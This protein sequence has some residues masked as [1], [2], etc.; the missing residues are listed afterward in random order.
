MS[1]VPR[2]FPFRFAISDELAEPAHTVCTLCLAMRTMSD[3][4]T[5][6]QNRTFFIEDEVIPTT[7][8]PTRK[9]RHRAGISRPAPPM[10]TGVS[11]QRDFFREPLRSSSAPCWCT[12]RRERGDHE[13][14]ASLSG[15]RQ[16]MQMTALQQLHEPKQAGR[17]ADEWATGLPAHPLRL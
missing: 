1:T 11:D 5:C 10:I 3:G 9:T 12:T 16:A 6:A 7:A 15:T 8:A 4:E 17:P 13:V 2:A 14:A